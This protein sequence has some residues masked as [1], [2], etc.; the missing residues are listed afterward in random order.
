MKTK[1]TTKED[2]LKMLDD[3]IIRKE[4]TKSEFFWFFNLYFCHHMRY[5]LAD[6]HKEIMKI[7]QNDNILL[8]IIM[9][10]RGSGKSTIIT[11]AYPLWAILGIQNK[12]YII[13]I[14][15]TKPQA[16]QM[17]KNIKSELESNDQLR[18]D[19]GPF[20][21]ESDEWGSESIVFSKQNAR[22]TA[23]SIEQSLKGLRH[24]QHRPDLIILDD[25]EDNESTKTREMRQKTYEKYKRDIVPLGDK[26]TRII[27]VGNMLHDNSL[28]MKLS[29]E[30]DEGDSVKVFKKYPIIDE[31]KNIYWIDKYSTEADVEE[32]RLK[33]NDD[34]AWYLEYLLQVIANNGQIIT[35]EEIQLY[36]ELPSRRI[37]RNNYSQRYVVVGVD[38]AISQ[39]DSADYTAIIPILYQKN[40]ERNCFEGYVLKD[41]IHK[42]L[43]FNELCDAIIYLNKSLLAYNSSRIIF[44]VED[45]G[46]QQAIIQ[47]VKYKDTAYINIVGK[48]YSL[49]K[50]SRL[51]IAK[52]IFSTKSIFFPRDS[53]EIIITELI[54]FGREKH[55]DLV[56]ALTLS[57]NYAYEAVLNEATVI[58]V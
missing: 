6:M 26:N 47:A 45:V 2:A 1:I 16:K 30:I 52:P 35:E 33:I 9:A 51:R 53:A 31:D 25:I 34:V 8:A 14:G 5:R 28:M 3:P 13:I 24:R 32:E 18:N 40:Q 22:I 56:D 57:I 15:K 38:P 48:H 43:N 4:I 42:R 36:D 46:F 27:H 29:R 39:N 55:D 21:E 10:F 23:V 11:T 54:G 41:F 19:L 44:V 49:D 7:C 12:K 50:E 17:M 37:K 20:Q 58:C